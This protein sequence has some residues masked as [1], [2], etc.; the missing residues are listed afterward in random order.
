MPINPDRPFRKPL[1]WRLMLYLWDAASSRT[2]VAVASAILRSRQLPFSTALTVDADTP[3][4]PARSWMVN[5][6]LLIRRGPCR[7]SFARQDHRW[8]N[9][10]R[11]LSLSRA[12][13]QERSNGTP[14]TT[15]RR[16]RRHLRG[17]SRLAS[18]D[19]GRPNVLFILS[20]D[21]GA[22][23]LGCGG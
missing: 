7:G 17:G 14:A 18:S 19:P 15:G 2:R 23:A 12:N 5:A 21:Q 11:K 3:A 10:L 8:H 22:W 4:S 6:R 16:A 13:R 1:A 9:R 20:A